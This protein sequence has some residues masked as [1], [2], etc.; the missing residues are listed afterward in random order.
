MLIFIL[1][2]CKSWT[3]SVDRLPAECGIDPGS[4]SSATKVIKLLNESGGELDAKSKATV[5]A[6]L[7]ENDKL[8]S[9][10]LTPQGCLRVE[11]NE[12]TVA[13]QT[14]SPARALAV[15]LSTLSRFNKLPFT[16]P[17]NIS[18]DLSCPN[19]GLFSNGSIPNP[20]RTAKSGQDLS[21]I[22]YRVE[23]L[24]DGE[25]FSPL[26]L[27]DRDLG[28]NQSIPDSFNVQNVP[29]GVYTMKVRFKDLSRTWESG[30]S[31]AT[32]SC[33]YAILHS[34][35]RF[36]G[37]S[38]ALNNAR[39][40]VY[41]QGSEIPLRADAAN[42]LVYSCSERRAGDFD[43]LGPTDVDCHAKDRCLKEENFIP[44]DRI[45]AEQSG[46][47]DYFVYLKD[48]AGNRSDVRCHR[49][50][51]T[52]AAPRLSLRWKQE[53]LNATAAALD[54]P[55]VLLDAQISVSHGSLSDA[56]TNES[57]SCK[58]DFLIGGRTVRDGNDVFCTHGR[59]SGQSL[60]S[61]V[62]C[63]HDF[64]L[65][66]GKAIEDP[67][68][69]RSIIRL[70]AKANDGAGHEE[71]TVR[72][73]LIQKGAW[74][75]QPLEENY[76]PGFQLADSQTEDIYRTADGRIL[77]RHPY[78]NQ[79]SLWSGNEFLILSPPDNLPD[80][81][82]L[83]AIVQAQGN[84]WGVW[85][86]ARGHGDETVFGLLVGDTWQRVIPAGWEQGNDRC[87]IYSEGKD[88]S[89]ICQGL[90]GIYRIHSDARLE[91]IAWSE[92]LPEQSCRLT[93]ALKD[94]PE[95]LLIAC[96]ASI[97]EY[98]NDWRE[99][100]IP[101]PETNGATGSF[102]SVQ[103]SLDSNFVDSKG[104]YWFQLQ[105]DPWSELKIGYYDHGTVRIVGAPYL[106]N[107]GMSV[108]SFGE[109]SAGIII[110]GAYTYLEDE[111]RWMLSED[112]SRTFQSTLV[113]SFLDADRRLWFLSN[114]FL[115]TEGALGPVVLPLK[116]L[117]FERIQRKSSVLLDK[118][119]TLWFIGKSAENKSFL[120]RL[121][122][123]KWLYFDKEG[124]DLPEGW[125]LGAWQ[126]AEGQSEVQ[127]QAEGVFRLGPEGWI[128]TATEQNSDPTPFRQ[129]QIVPRRQGGY[130]SKSYRG[131]SYTA[132]GRNWIPI[133]PQGLPVNTDMA[134]E[135][136]EQDERGKSWFY[137]SEMNR[138]LIA[139][140]ADVTEI[141]L[142][143]WA[144]ND[145]AV[146]MKSLPN[147]MTILSRYKIY[148][149]LLGD[150]QV[151]E[152]QPYSA[153]G[154][155]SAARVRRSV[156]SN[157][158][159]VYLLL[160]DNSVWKINLLAR[161]SERLNLPFNPAIMYFFDFQVDA[162]NRLYIVTPMT[163]FRLEADH[164]WSRLLEH[165]DVRVDSGQSQLTFSGP[166]WIDSEQRLWFSTSAQFVRMDLT[167]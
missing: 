129:I 101:L 77:A 61:F 100:A 128:K 145:S 13:I 36:S 53:A 82:P 141:H 117:N 126:T 147:K 65:S 116:G 7:Q 143:E 96:G 132:D 17:L 118:D 150:S 72:T 144:D 79:Q 38:L 111:S 154:L 89:L 52:N 60:G 92:D 165:K 114:G 67:Q 115:Q 28:E 45:L 12:G 159:D 39:E 146:F 49:A 149:R 37:E 33:P 91:K 113:Q 98:K 105:S 81:M 125:A 152:S 95:A 124:T 32:A 86:G 112:V 133:G 123:R 102:T 59:C 66:L 69:L 31:T 10:S 135:G 153:Y 75:I 73:L 120:H 51:V 23:L 127:I 22:S 14:L 110:F 16:A 46:V 58:V 56:K 54:S 78:K 137:Q 104:R 5:R 88:G 19:E 41:S 84:I 161:R 157:Q 122:K 9:L 106:Y 83:S 30:E 47:Y 26:I 43:D 18:I 151:F 24:K 71:S 119:G 167:E 48:R 140:Q 1:V 2:S 11:G 8:S 63:D 70:T 164:S 34:A 160:D 97:F 148:S 42:S 87:Y 131:L 121:K 68:V 134:W 35:P 103:A 27:S 107:Q 80:S 55:T 21:Y 94:A 57:L 90:G 20:L 15:K 76:F 29:E 74:D 136:G 4:L 166:V 162:K 155:N 3:N 6:R 93:D 130:Y 158:R 25:P 139:D 108:Q 64:Q 85:Y 163:V 138:F 109:T 142:N 99:I 62:P 50:F 156:A 40:G 44:V